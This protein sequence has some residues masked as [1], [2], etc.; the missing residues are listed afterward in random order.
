MA[1]IQGAGGKRQ[2]PTSRFNLTFS[3]QIQPGR[4][5]EEVKREL[6]QLLEIDDPAELD[7]IFSGDTVVLRRDLERK[8]AAE[9]YS[10]LQK[11]G[12]M[13]ELVKIADQRTGGAAQPAKNASRPASAPSGQA[14]TPAARASRQY[15][16]SPPIALCIQPP[17]E[18]D[19]PGRGSLI[20]RRVRF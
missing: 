10:R 16:N 8:P 3:G 20:R 17:C 12:A 15:V 13:A 2:G 5:P 7:V 14:T 6:G 9:F 11:I 1:A 4:D 19:I 18:T